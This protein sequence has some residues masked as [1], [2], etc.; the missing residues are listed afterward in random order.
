MKQASLDIGSLDFSSMKSTGSHIHYSISHGFEDNQG[1]LSYYLV[2]DKPGKAWMIQPGFITKMFN[3]VI[4]QHL[5]PQGKDV[6]YYMTHFHELPVKGRKGL[7]K[8]N[9][10]G[11]VQTFVATVVKVPK[12]GLAPR[13]YITNVLDQVGTFMKRKDVGDMF[14]NWLEGE[15]PGLYRYFVGCKEGE[16][17]KKTKAQIGERILKTFNNEFKDYSCDYNVHLSSFM[18]D[19]EIK[20]FLVNCLGRNSFNEVAETDLSKIFAYYPHNSLPIWENITKE[21]Y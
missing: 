19:Y 4:E 15:N 6:P 5:N 11:Y 14:A 8:R 12:M 7:Y 18:C 21:S 17:P 10:K 9:A 16:P 1:N 3:V 2:L 13:L 20:Q